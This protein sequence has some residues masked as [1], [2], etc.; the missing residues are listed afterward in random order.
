MMYDK[1]NRIRH[2][3]AE[4][5]ALF[6]VI[7]PKKIVCDIKRWFTWTCQ[8][9]VKPLRDYMLQIAAVCCDHMIFHVFVL[10]IW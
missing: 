2:Y 6:V 4:H 7:L 8:V 10:K 1:R 9:V 3:P 5:R